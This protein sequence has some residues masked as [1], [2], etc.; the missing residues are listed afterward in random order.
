MEHNEEVQKLAKTLKKSG[1][2][3][4]DEDSI[5]IAE[6]MIKGED[7]AVEEIKKDDDA[8]KENL[9]KE[10]AE[11]IKEKIHLGKNKEVEEE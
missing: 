10:I 3:S 8:K 7:T 1:L 5:K 9:I 2:A 6:K 4:S 11:D